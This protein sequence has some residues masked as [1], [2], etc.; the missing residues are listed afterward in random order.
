VIEV[1]VFFCVLALMLCS[2]LQREL[3]RRGIDR[4]IRSLLK[5]LSSIREIGILFRP[6]GSQKAPALQ[7]TVSRMAADQRALYDALDLGRYAAPYVIRKAAA[8]LFTT[9]TCVQTA[10]NLGF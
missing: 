2:L 1:H 6:D 8:I 7:T 3:H 9:T 5:D 10:V 4:S